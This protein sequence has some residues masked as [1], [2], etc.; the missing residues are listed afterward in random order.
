LPASSWF[1]AAVFSFWSPGLC[2][3]GTVT[4][5]A[6]RPPRDQV[7]SWCCAHRPTSV[8][9][10]IFSSPLGLQ[11]SRCR[12]PALPSFARGYDLSSRVFAARLL[13]QLVCRAPGVGCS[14]LVRVQS[15]RH[16]HLRLFSARLCVG[17]CR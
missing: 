11:S 5:S 3:A 13:L 1:T 7:Q 2:P 14:G 8:F 17:C 15:T 4:P 10:S 12:H 9:S 16:C 6:C